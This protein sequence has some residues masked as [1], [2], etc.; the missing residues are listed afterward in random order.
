MSN[1]GYLIRHEREQDRAEK[2]RE[3]CEPTVRDELMDAL[4]IDSLARRDFIEWLTD[5][6][7]EFIAEMTNPGER[8][9]KEILDKWKVRYADVMLDSMG[10]KNV[11]QAFHLWTGEEYDD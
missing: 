2:R 5:E 11:A 7:K 6:A 8:T 1:E 10:W 4:E 9:H 3:C